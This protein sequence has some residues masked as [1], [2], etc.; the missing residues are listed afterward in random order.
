MTKI[1][2][3]ILP[4]SVE[5]ARLIAELE[6][7]MSS[8]PTVEEFQADTDAVLSWRGRAQATMSAWNT[9]KAIQFNSAISKLEDPFY[10]EDRKSAMRDVRALLHEARHSMLLETSGTSNVAVPAGNVFQY[11]S[12]LSKKIS[13]AQTDILFADPYLD[14]TFIDRY[15]PQVGAGVPVRLLTSKY[16]SKLAPAIDLFCKQH[17]NSISLRE[18]DFHDRFVFID[19]K[20]AFQS[21]ASFKDGAST[22]PTGLV[23][24]IDVFPATLSAY[25]ALWS[26][27][28]VHR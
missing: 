7:V 19:R 12:E 15:L 1:P 25:E 10:P 5:P 9:M 21:G 8:I 23:E 13:M 17:G 6:L 2:S 3:R 20:I 27:G 24:I 11:F 16:I 22:A 26:G 14:V 4:P 18:A 28:K